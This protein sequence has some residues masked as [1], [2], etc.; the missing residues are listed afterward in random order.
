MREGG[1][2]PKLDQADQDQTDTGKNAP[3]K[4]RK[5]HAHKQAGHRDDTAHVAPFRFIGEEVV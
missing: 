3:R 4:I 5:E 1:S 2:P